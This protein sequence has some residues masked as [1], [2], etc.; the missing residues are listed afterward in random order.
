MPQVKLHPLL[1]LLLAYSVNCFGS[2]TIDSTTTIDNTCTNNGSVTVYAHSNFPPLIYSIIDGPF[3]VQNQN[4]NTFFGLEPGVYEVLITNYNND[5]ATTFIAINGSYSYPDFSL[6]KQNT[7]CSQKTDGKIII[8]PVT[9]S[10][11]GSFSYKLINN[12]THQTNA[13][14][15]DTIANLEAA[16]YTVIATDACGNA[17]TKSISINSPSTAIYFQYP[18]DYAKVGCDSVKVGIYLV[19]N[20]LQYTPITLKV[21]TKNGT[22]TKIANIVWGSRLEEIIPN[23]TYGDSVK[24][25]LTTSCGDK[26][27]HMFWIPE[28]KFHF[29]P[30]YPFSNCNY[31]NN[32]G[33]ISG[34]GITLPLPVYCTL[35]DKQT[36]T[37]LENQ[38]INYNTQTITVSPHPEGKEYIYNVTDGCGKTLIDTFF[39]APLDS[40]IKTRYSTFIS[41][42]HCVDSTSGIGVDIFN[43]PTNNVFF[44]MLSGPPGSKSSKPEYTY[45]IS[46]VYNQ[47]F[48]FLSTNY[49]LFDNLSAGTYYYQIADDCGH[50]FIDSITIL[51]KDIADDNYSVTVKKGCDGQNCLLLNFFSKN[52][53]SCASYTEGDCSITDLQTGQ[54][55]D[56]RHFYYYPPFKFSD[57][58][59][60]PY[61]NAGDY[62]INITYIDDN[63][64]NVFHL[65]STPICWSITKTITIPPYQRPRIRLYNKISCH[66]NRFI[67]FRADSNK[68]VLPFHYEIISGPQT[69][70]IQYSNLFQISQSGNYVA[71][72]TDSCGTSNTFFFAIDTF[73]FPPMGKL[74]SSC[75][76]GVTKLC[77]TPSSFFTYK[78]TRPNGTVF[79]GDTLLI[80]PTTPADL[81]VYHITKIT[82][83]N[84]CVDSVSTTYILN[85]NKMYYRYDTICPLQSLSVGTHTYTQTGVYR[86]TFPNGSCDSI[87]ITD[88]TVEYNRDTLYQTICI[89]QYYSFNNKN[90]TATGIYRDTSITS[91]CVLITTLYLQVKP[92]KRGSF[93]HSICA[94]ESY[95]FANRN[96]NTTG[97]YRDTL[98]T[99]DCDSISTLY[100][101]VK[102]F[103]RGK[104]SIAICAGKKYYVGNQL[105]TVDGTY[106][107]TL[108][109]E[110]GCDSIITLTIHIKPY[111]ARSIAASFC[112]GEQFKVWGKMYTVQG[113]YIDTLRTNACDSI[114]QVSI[115][116]WPR[117][118]GDTT[119]Q[120]LEM[121]FEDTLEL[122]AC[123]TDQNYLWNVAECQTCQSI[124][125]S[126]NKEYNEYQCTI[127]NALGCSI[128]C[129]YRVKV[130]GLT[131]KLYVPNAFTH[132]GDGTND[133]FRIFGRAIHQNYLQIFNR[134]GEVVFYS[135]NIDAGWDGTY[136]GQ[137]QPVGI[138]VYEL[139]YFS[140]VDTVSKIKKGSLTLLR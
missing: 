98:S 48:H 47:S 76:G 113:T 77:Y 25:M 20:G 85:A 44:T 129:H 101:I 91:N 96:L 105:I 69:Y 27:L 131:G 122:N 37:V 56:T 140:G 70:P 18:E 86:D 9:G 135:D 112:E 115:T 24:I 78:W 15:S 55:V 28:F 35:K 68:G 39:W 34:L 114:F 120:F 102:D 61:L 49:N 137:P 66:G 45:H 57:T 130:N 106:L 93:L 119:L 80:N 107:D 138:Y 26:S 1:L 82:N 12:N 17:T 84:G 128:H 126:P 30:Y 3:T 139:N 88:L 16:N 60:V 132:N 79:V 21:T 31:Y 53:T 7:T 95:F 11:K 90:L 81:G 23:V 6:T 125:I 64:G 40:T 63:L 116:V 22:Y 58:A 123:A 136:R 54:I 87:V 83:Y 59:S 8:A 33:A 94:G 109:N 111:G 29:I 42:R 72:I 104:D 2:I 5:S 50:F 118:I 75:I 89:G 67:E 92:Y 108:H 51:P 10:G 32:G 73:S 46:N 65:A 52:D 74:G 97:I 133:F 13:I 43:F 117:P 36:G 4:A 134:W 100:L 38:I 103:Q 71:R 19:G 14:F 124:H 121:E 127:T 110:S 62:A 99:I 41:G